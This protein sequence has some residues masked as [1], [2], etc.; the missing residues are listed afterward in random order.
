M[1]R[2]IEKIIITATLLRTAVPFINSISDRKTASIDDVGRSTGFDETEPA[3]RVSA[4]VQPGLPHLFWDF[5]LDLSRRV[6]FDSGLGLIHSLAK[7]VWAQ[8]ERAKKANAGCRLAK[9]PAPTMRIRMMCKSN[10]AD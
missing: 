8:H 1:D 10:R 9:I 5:K 7:I 2:T 4:R 6:E 3:N